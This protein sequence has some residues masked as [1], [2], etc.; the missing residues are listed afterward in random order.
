VEAPGGG[1]AAEGGGDAPWI[2]TAAELRA[3]AVLDLLR[4]SR[5]SEDGVRSLAFE[6]L[7]DHLAE[8]SLAPERDLRLDLGRGLRQLLVLLQQ[9]SRGERSGFEGFQVRERGLE[10]RGVDRGLIAME[11]LLSG[12]ERL[13]VAMVR[14][15]LLQPGETVYW[16]VRPAR[17]RCRIRWRLGRRGWQ[18]DLAERQARRPE[19][20]S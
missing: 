19:L 17:R 18:L 20:L 15:L 8:R 4:H 14:D 1:P 6:N 12:M 2:G 11:E 5:G 16:L 3:P 9:L 10:R 13:L 7:G